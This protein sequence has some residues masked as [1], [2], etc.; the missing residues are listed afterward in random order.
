MEE[1]VGI[2]IILNGTKYR[3]APGT[4][5]E[6]LLVQL[7]IPERGTAVEVGGEIVAPK[8]LREMVLLQGQK[9][10]IVRLVGGG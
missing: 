10:E 9:V 1:D 2:E 3:V 5:V 6:Q 8:K 7:E 4:T